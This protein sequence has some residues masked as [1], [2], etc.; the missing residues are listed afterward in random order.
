MRCLLGLAAIVMATGCAS[1]LREPP[2]AAVLAGS[3]PVAVE[4]DADPSA[5]IDRASASF[6]RRPDPQAVE[7]ARDLS[8]HAMAADDTPLEAFVG[9][10][11]ATA[12]LIEHEPDA[13]RREALSVE[14]VQIAQLCQRRYPA[15]P[16]CRYRLALAVG[17]QARERPSTATDGLDIMV[18][19]LE[20]LVAEAPDLDAAGPDRVLALVLL[21]APGWPSGPGDPELGLEHARAAAELAPDHPPN[22]IVLG[23]ALLENGGAVE[24]R[25]ALERALALAETLAVRGDPDAPEWRAEARR[26]LG[27]DR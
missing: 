12:W 17:Q 18:E 22:Q 19:L 9:A 7:Q 15:E 20:N 16:E 24:G 11:R 27:Q 8:L 6:A 14:G 4:P 25:R 23:E 1:A 13:D 21:R 10:A 5:L 3:G 26:T 2:P